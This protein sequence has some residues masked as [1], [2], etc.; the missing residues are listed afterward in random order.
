MAVKQ[1]SVL[2]ADELNDLDEEII[3]AL[4]DGRGTPSYLAERLNRNR[5]YVS[6]RLKRLAEHD[7]LIKLGTGLY[8]LVDDPRR[9]TDEKSAG[10]DIDKLREQLREARSAHETGNEEKLAATLERM[11]YLLQD[12]EDA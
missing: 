3:D 7:H 9:G 10:V 4:H 12:E 11:D 6:Q 1:P 2:A 8:E 5:S